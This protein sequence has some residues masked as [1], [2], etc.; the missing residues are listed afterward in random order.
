[1]SKPTPALV[2]PIEKPAEAK[3]AIPESVVDVPSQRLYYLSL[4]VLC[5][6]SSILTTGFGIQRFAVTGVQHHS[7]KFHATYPAFSL[8]YRLTIP[9]FVF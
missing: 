7:L 8:H 5:Q 2:V 9:F 4:G 6:V 1:M 3:P